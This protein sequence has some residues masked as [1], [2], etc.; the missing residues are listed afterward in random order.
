M[1]SNIFSLFAVPFVQVVHPDSRALNA[2]LSHL[3]LTLEAQGDSNRNAS[4]KMEIPDALFE[5]TFD[6]F[7]RSEPCV[8]ELRRFC[9][10]WLF[11]T[12]GELSDLTAPQLNALTIKSHTWF[13]VTRNAGFFSLHNHPMASWSGVYCVAPGDGVGSQNGAVTFFN[14]MGAGNMFM[15]Q[16]NCRLKL[17]FSSGNFSLRQQAGELILFPSYLFHQVLPYFGKT[18]RITIAFNCWFP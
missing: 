8:M 2:A 17:P 7:N 5:S 15:D 14:P 12:I 4:P 13:H 9:F 11:K 18:E 10:S 16:S 3:I 6:F 1:Q